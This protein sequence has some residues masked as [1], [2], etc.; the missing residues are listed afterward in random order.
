MT[1]IRSS[2]IS[3][4]YLGR[5]AFP[6]VAASLQ[7]SEF[8][9]GE[10]CSVDIELRVVRKRRH[11]RVIH[12][13]QL[14]RIGVVRLE[15]GGKGASISVVDIRLGLLHGADSVPLVY[16]FVSAHCFFS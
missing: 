13:R 11:T 3:N 7:L 12:S 15:E 6:E 10:S 2:S 16:P 1:F 4:W 8:E 14:E 9:L 5:H